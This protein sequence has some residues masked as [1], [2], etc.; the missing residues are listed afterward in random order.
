MT[1]L[2]D[3]Y[4]ET[5][6]WYHWPIQRRTVLIAVLQRRMHLILPLS[7]SRDSLINILHAVQ[8]IDSVLA[9][10]CSS[11]DS[12]TLLLQKSNLLNYVTQHHE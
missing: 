9:L 4:T 6:A 2:T 8:V 11:S 7:V 5:E 3:F 12:T 1:L 10:L